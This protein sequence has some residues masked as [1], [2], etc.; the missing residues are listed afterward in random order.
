MKAGRILG[1]LG[2]LLAAGCVQPTLTNLTVENNAV[3]RDPSGLYPV[4]MEWLS[5]DAAV[6]HDTIKPVVLVGA[7]K[8]YPMRRQHATL[9]T[10]QWVAQVP[11]D[12]K[13]TELRYRIKV[14]WQLKGPAEETDSQR[15][16]EF[17][18]RIVD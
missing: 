5:N 10:N 7:T 1:L 12:S 2:G 18:L 11:V 13:A 3:K 17:L 8:V 4:E 15:S 14:T 6:M 16:R 9:L